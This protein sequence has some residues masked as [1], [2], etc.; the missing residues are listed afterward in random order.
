MMTAMTDAIK[1]TKSTLTPLY[2]LLSDA[3]KKVADQLIQGPMGMGHL[4]H[5][6]M[7]MGSR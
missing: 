5:G 7:G 1:A 2:A 4:A 6:P 3:Q